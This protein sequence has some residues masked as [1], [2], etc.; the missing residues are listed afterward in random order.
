M[1]ATA[2]STVRRVEV[3]GDVILT[4][5]PLEAIFLR[6]LLSETSGCSGERD[7]PE[8]LS[9]SIYGALES[10][11][12]PNS[13]NDVARGGDIEFESDAMHGIREA[14]KLWD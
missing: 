10:A 1:M 4:L 13:D 9:S 11:G 5:S 14:M 8:T 2:K 7:D 6:S 12:V 3:Q